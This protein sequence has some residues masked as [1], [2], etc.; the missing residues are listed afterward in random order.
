[1][2]IL[3]KNNAS[4]FLATAVNAT[5]TGFV[6]VSGDGGN[7]PSLGVGEYFYAT[8]EDANDNIEIVKVT[9]RS[10]DALTVVRAQ[11]DTTAISFAAGTRV[12]MRVNAQTLRDL[13]NEGT[14]SVDAGNVSY[15]YPATGGSLRT[16]EA[17]LSD[18]VT[19][20][21]FGA[22]GDGVTDD[23]DAVR[24][25]F[26][27]GRP[28]NGLNK[29]YKVTADTIID[30]S[31]SA[32]V[33]YGPN[34]AW[35]LIGVCHDI[36]FIGDVSFGTNSIRFLG[37][38]LFVS[39]VEV[40]GDLRISSWY[41]QYSGLR[42]SGTTYMNGDYPPV[43]N[44]NGCYVNRITASDFNG[45]F[46]VDQRYGPVNLNTF[47]ECQ[48]TTF[49]VKDTGNAGYASG[50][51]PFK[52]F[53]L[54]TFIS[55]EWTSGGI[56]APDGNDYVFVIQD[57]ANIGGLNKFIG[58]YTEYPNRGFY[59]GVQIEMQHNSAQAVNHGGGEIGYNI[60]H[61]GEGGMIQ[62]DAP[63]IYPAH[64]LATGGDWSILDANG[65]PECWSTANM[66]VTT[67]TD[68]TE[69][70][71][72]NK[73]VQFAA[74]TNFAVADFNFDIAND[75]NSRTLRSYA[76][77]YKVISGS[78]T[79]IVT[80]SGGADL[81]GANNT[82]RLD[83]GWVLAYGHTYGNVRFTSASLFT[84]QVSAASAGRG[85]G[86]LS[87]AGKLKPL[88]DLSGGASYVGDAITAAQSGWYA[89][90]NEKFIDNTDGNVTFFT[91]A[92]GN[93]TGRSAKISANL[94]LASTTG[95]ARTWYRESI[96]NENGAAAL[97]EQNIHN[98]TGLNGSLTFNATGST[99]EIRASSLASGFLDR[100]R[101][102]IHVLGGGI[103]SSSV[104]VL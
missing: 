74:N 60:P 82:T 31:A 7:F 32:G 89:N 67:G 28:V 50:S 59:G 38:H 83:D 47:T 39:H 80:N 93:F 35:F 25:A 45:P 26:D 5:D 24:A 41:T 12:E 81:Y 37:K 36:K 19:P 85:A 96:F 64:S 1:M 72:L 56:T 71:G 30:P 69:P 48:F 77:I 51:E 33:G 87:P 57:T 8:L 53:H 103:T 73:Y 97:V 52:D 6:L 18:Y 100:A 23:S 9:A 70:T 49:E 11:D 92:L 34:K 79:V 78:P 27:T 21:D 95:G 29:T 20:L 15:T 63:H 91:V 61:S 46:V 4:G 58:C 14:V 66:T 76:I 84:I 16:V 65:V 13:V 42:V 75:A 86:V 90:D 40:D 2:T 98:I 17:R 68:N 55:C 102:A 43:V 99:V 10:G 104:T 101:M 3:I 44:F 22:V 62:R 88:I 94:S 54:N